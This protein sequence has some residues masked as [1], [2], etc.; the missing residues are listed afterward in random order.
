MHLF[1]FPTADYIA[2]H[3]FTADFVEEERGKNEET[4]CITEGNGVG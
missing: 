4:P 3:S 2:F 1:M